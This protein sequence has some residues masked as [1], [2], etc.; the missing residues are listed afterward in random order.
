VMMAADLFRLG[1]LERFIEP[2]VC[3]RTLS[4]SDS[5]DQHGRTL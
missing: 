2:A 4:L 1:D 3:Q 5:Q